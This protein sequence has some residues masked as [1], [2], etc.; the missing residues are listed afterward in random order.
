MNRP[1][2]GPCPIRLTG[3]WV[4]IALLL[5]VA[6]LFLAGPVSTEGAGR[7]IAVRNEKQFAAAVRALRHS[8][9]TIVLL[10]R[11]YRGELLVPP[12]SGRLLRIVGRP[13]TYVER[14]RLDHAQRVSIGRLRI[15]P[16]TGDAWIEA[17]NSRDLHFHNLVVSAAG[18]RYSATILM[19]HSRRVT[20]RRSLFTHCGDRSEIFSNCVTLRRVKRL[21]IEGNRFRDCRGCDFIHG[22]F[23]SHLTIRKNRFER[24]LPCRMTRHRCGHQDLISIFAGKVLVIEN[25][26]FGVYR[27]GGAQLYLT[28][29]VDH[30]R[31]A[32]NV[33]IG[34][35]PRVPGY[36]SRV[37]MVIGARES[38]RL[39]HHVR[40]VNNTI[41]T[42]ASRVD[43]YAGSIRMSSL[44]G[45]V[46]PRKRP[47]LANNVIAL[48][49]VPN[50][51]CSVVKAS[52]S[53]LVLS[54]TAC[55]KSDRTGD[56]GLDARGRPTRASRLL[57]DRASGLYAPSR[58][59]TG[60]PRGQKPDIGAFEYR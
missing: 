19:P 3:R 30:V 46:H 39:P 16:V 44:Y 25:N 4:Q 59:R 34:R 9:G 55:S 35:D 14:I 56:A 53:N 7:A 49:K 40:I 47:I 58:D 6:G 20:I 28:N 51:V 43:G 41:L 1:T 22:R 57:I 23:S 50:H 54:G 60:R 42:G 11:V 29:N 27:R 38:V 12:R 45:A 17:D 18:T 24:A 8:G 32:N 26:Y 2:R 15:G 5:A 33:F 10:P 52:V 48:L 21:T 13:G 37:A 36:R 31:I